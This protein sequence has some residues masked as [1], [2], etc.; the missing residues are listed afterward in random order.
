MST[1]SA[2]GRSAFGSQLRER[3]IVGTDCPLSIAIKGLRVVGF[4]TFVM[5]ISIRHL[6]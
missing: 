1:R 2:K 6:E 4:R 3:P 5:D